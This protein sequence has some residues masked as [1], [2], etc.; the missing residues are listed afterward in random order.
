M[1][2]FILVALAAPPAEA[3]LKI[4]VEV[5]LA[6]AA[7]KPERVI[8]QRASTPAA[9]A[10][11]PL[12]KRPVRDW[13]GDDKPCPC[14]VTGKPCACPTPGACGSP[15]CPSHCAEC[16]AAAQK[17]AALEYETVWE[18]VCTFD[19]FGRK[20]GCQLIPKQ[21]PKAKK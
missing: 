18:Q 21:V 11:A 9:P 3:Q 16:A 13:F 14:C 20:V 10:P 1:V 15:D 2:G 6:L 19:R 4:E 8:L 12:A 7:A 5:A 17:A